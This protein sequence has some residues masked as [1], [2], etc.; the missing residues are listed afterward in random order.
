VNL[1]ALDIATLEWLIIAVFVV[2]VV[3]IELLFW[4]RRE[5]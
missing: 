1:G 3:L 5:N 4:I 2:T